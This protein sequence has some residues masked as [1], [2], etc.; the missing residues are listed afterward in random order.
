M[1]LALPPKWQE[2]RDV[3]FTKRGMV[4]PLGEVVPDRA[5]SVS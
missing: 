3:W 1:R 4:M 5:E 2:R